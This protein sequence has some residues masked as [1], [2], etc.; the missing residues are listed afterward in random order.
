M[1]RRSR[2]RDPDQEASQS[3]CCPP[4]ALP[5][6]AMAVH[7]LPRT[8]IGLGTIMTFIG[9]IL[10]SVGYL[11]NQSTYGNWKTSGPILLG[12]GL[13]CI[14]GG[15]L[16][17]Y[18]RYRSGRNYENRTV[19]LP[20]GMH[21]PGKAPE[22]SVYT[23]NGSS[24]G[25][26]PA[27]PASA[28]KSTTRHTQPQGS[29][30]KPSASSVAT[31]NTGVTG[32]SPGVKRS[33]AN[34]G[35]SFANPNYVPSQRHGLL[36]PI[37]PTTEARAQSQHSSTGGDK[38]PDILMS[39]S[40]VRDAHDRPSKGQGL[41]R[42]NGEVAATRTSMPYH[43]AV[44]ATTSH[45]PA[46]IHEGASNEGFEFSDSDSESETKGK[47]QSEYVDRSEGRS[48]RA[49]RD[50]SAT[51]KTGASQGFTG[52]MSGEDLFMSRNS[53][54]SLESDDPDGVF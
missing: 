28:A 31:T 1:G 2:P 48:V 23:I 36:P 29:H 14:V 26:D 16:W 32:T 15:F 25:R 6:L 43:P 21:H 3:E 42:M 41:D 51:G 45:T 24:G 12:F 40:A 39:G 20:R 34:K 52:D 37:Q 8:L 17:M 9:I 5:Y 50:E 49:P 7:Y 13:G 46:R 35:Q 27:L 53:G 10:T 4:S 47:A 18:W 38:K 30:S 11:E 44:D 22:H 33:E 19:E 54:Y